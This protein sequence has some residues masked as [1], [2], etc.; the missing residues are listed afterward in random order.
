MNAFLEKYTTLKEDRRVS[1]YDDAFLRSLEERLLDNPDE[2]QTIAELTDRQ[3][4]L[5]KAYRS[6]CEF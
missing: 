5:L 4:K 3:G 6:G 2:K 1:K